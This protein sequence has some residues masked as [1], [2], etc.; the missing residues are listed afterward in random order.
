MQNLWHHFNFDSILHSQVDFIC[1]WISLPQ[2]KLLRNHLLV[3]NYEDTSLCVNI[4]WMVYC[5]LPQLFIA[6]FF[7][8]TRDTSWPTRRLSLVRNSYNSTRQSTNIKGNNSRFREPRRTSGPFG[9][10]THR[11]STVQ[12]ANAK[13]FISLQNYCPTQWP[14]G[15]FNSIY[16]F[17]V[18][19]W[20]LF[21]SI[22]WKLLM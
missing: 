8:R 7:H 16:P 3:C 14:G 4:K 1:H 19:F 22:F 17:R 10:W 18:I 9:N 2:L 12:I 20:A 15:Q 6:E 11:T 13:G 5:F 21:L